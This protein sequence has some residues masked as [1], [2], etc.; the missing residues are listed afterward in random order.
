MSTYPTTPAYSGQTAGAAPAK[1]ATLKAA[2]GVTILAALAAIV[3]GIMILTG[4]PELAREIAANAVSILT[5]ESID[6]ILA[7]GGSI[8]DVAAEAATSTLQTR[9]YLLIVPGALVLLFGLL[10]TKAATWARV[11]VTISAAFLL[12]FAGIISLDTVGSTGTMLAI[13][14]VATLGAI[15]S[16]VLTWLSPNGRYA[17]AL[18]QRA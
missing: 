7:E 13:G 14:W 10:M 15:A 8:L 11:M 6:T 5:G 16:I 2:L 12:L 18:K 9:A 3:N 4:G 17:K 1:P